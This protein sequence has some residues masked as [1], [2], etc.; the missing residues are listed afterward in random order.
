MIEDTLVEDLGTSARPGSVKI[1]GAVFKHVTVRGKT[2]E[3]HIGPYLAHVR[4]W[5][6]TS[7]S[8]L[9]RVADRLLFGVPRPERE[10]QLRAANR[11][12]YADV[13]WALDITEAQAP[14]LTL[15]GI[16]A[17]LIR[18]D[19]RSQAVVRR[20]KVVEAGP[21]GLEVLANAPHFGLTVRSM[22]E[23]GFD[24]VVIVA[25]RRSEKYAE[26]QRAIDMLREAGL[27][28]AN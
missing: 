10:E 21:R 13:D 2:A 11:A 20:Q 5:A 7:G 24:D 15:E 3:L 17:D 23:N 1:E 12:Y 19:S 4:E 9:G 6:P 14:D 27:A 22:I 16:P 25:G 28:E 26:R 8:F 18:R